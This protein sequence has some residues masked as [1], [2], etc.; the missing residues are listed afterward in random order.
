MPPPK[1]PIELPQDIGSTYV[2]W[3]TENKCKDDPTKFFRKIVEGLENNNHTG[4]RNMFEEVRR[5]LADELV[6]DFIDQLEEDLIL[7]HPEVLPEKENLASTSR[8]ATAEY[9]TQI[10][11][12]H[13]EEVS[14][15]IT[16]LLQ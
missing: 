4:F 15:I 11:K 16:M 1:L 13:M 5:D 14:I 8:G 7:P 2:A 12:T 10:P 9:Q 3:V 6:I